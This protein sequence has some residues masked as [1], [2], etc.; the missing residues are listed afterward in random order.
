MNKLP[1]YIVRDMLP[2][3]AEDL[4]TEDSKKDVEQHLAEC[5]DCSEL[6]RQMTSPEPEF[7]VDT[8]EVDPR[9]MESKRVRGLYFAGEILNC[10]AYTG[11]FNLQ[12]AWSTAQ[13]AATHVACG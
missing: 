9:T 11:G 6:Y 2:Q 7:E 3:Y 5:E 4:L 8:A 13:A 10:D 1:C 12:I